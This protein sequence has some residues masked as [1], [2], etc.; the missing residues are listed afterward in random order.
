MVVHIWSFNISTRDNSTSNQSSNVSF[1]DVFIP[2]QDPSSLSR[3]GHT[4][5]AVFLGFILLFGLLNNLLVLLIFA[6]FRSL[7]TPINLILLN[8]SV[9]DILVCMFG[10]PFS[11]AASLYGRWLLGHHGCKWYG[12]ANSLFGIVSLVSLSVLSYERYAAV[13]SSSKA[14]LSDFRKAWMYVAGSWLYS[15]VW[16]LPPFLGWSSYGP[17]GAG[18]SCSVQWQQ[19]SANSVSYVVCLFVFCLLLPLLLMVYCYSKILL[20]IRGVAKINIMSAQRR[21]NHILLMVL[22]MVSCY[23]LCWMPYG[24]MALVATFGKRGL[25]T[26]TASV[27]PSVLAKSSTVVNPVIYV[28]FN[29]QFYRCFVAFVKCGAE[30]QSIHT[31]QPQQSSRDGNPTLCTCKPT[32]QTLHTPT[33]SHTHSHTHPEQQQKETRALSLV[34]HYTP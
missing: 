2:P 10:T 20:I 22:T 8:I 15:L 27:V 21:E 29:N 17:E 12:F 7:W 3:T 26:T 23:L 9:S 4:V 13:L 19:R 34:V 18:T 33:P 16:T 24:V 25:I 6:K 30:P 28:L 11:F 5:V 32:E 14:D 31:L 1:G